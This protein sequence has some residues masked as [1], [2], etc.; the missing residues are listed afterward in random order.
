MFSDRISYERTNLTQHIG[1]ENRHK[2]HQTDWEA[3]KKNP[4]LIKIVH[5]EW[6]LSHDA[7]KYAE[8]NT[9]NALQALRSGTPFKST[10]V[11]DEYVHQDWDVKSLMELD[12]QRAH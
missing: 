6:L 1:W 12:A 2:F 9:E 11:P 10:N 4:G 7:E 8:E 5:D 3:V